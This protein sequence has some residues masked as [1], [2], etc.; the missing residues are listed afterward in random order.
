MTVTQPSRRRAD[1]CCARRDLAVVRRDAGAARRQL[2]S[3]PARSSPS[4]GRAA[5]ASRRCCTAWPASSCPTRRDPLRRRARRHDGRDRAQHA[6]PGP[7][8]V[9]LPVRPARARA[10]RRGERR[11]AAAARR[12]P[13]APRRSA[14]PGAGSSGSASAGWSSAAPASCPAGRRSGSRWPAGWSPARGAVRRRADRLARLAHRRAGHGPAGRRGP[15]AG[16]HGR[17]GHPRARVAAY[18]DREV[19]VRD[20]T[21]GAPTPGWRR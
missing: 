21:G 6:A 13:P 2:S 7:V 20:G 4:W 8:R 12:R 1:R 15:R 9:R 10:D 14:G 17:A 5:R 11:P 18:A 3:R 16:H 19:I